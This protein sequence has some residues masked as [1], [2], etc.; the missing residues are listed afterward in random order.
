MCRRL[1]GLSTYGLKAY[2]R[3]ISEAPR[4]ISTIGHGQA[5]P[6]YYKIRVII[7]STGGILLHRLHI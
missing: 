4:L 7:T 5:L 3:E 2:V 1:C 6:F